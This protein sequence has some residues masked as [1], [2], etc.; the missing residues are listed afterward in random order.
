MHGSRKYLSE[1]GPT[2]LAFLF[3]FLELMREGRKEPNTTKS[4]HHRPTS[5]TPLNLMAQH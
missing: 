4:G 5:E 2:T 3:F 1:W